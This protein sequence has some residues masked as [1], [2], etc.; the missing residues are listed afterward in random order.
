MTIAFNISFNFTTAIQRQTLAGKVNQKKLVARSL[1]KCHYIDSGVARFFDLVQRKAPSTKYMCAR[2]IQRQIAHTKTL[3]NLTK[4]LSI[5][6][7]NQSFWPRVKYHQYY[8]SSGRNYFKTI[9][10]FSSILVL[11]FP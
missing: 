11:C 4:Y 7:Q 3:K 2:A 5:L 8:R 9:Q 1:W 10:I 6:L